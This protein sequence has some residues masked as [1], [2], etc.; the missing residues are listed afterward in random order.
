MNTSNYYPGARGSRPTPLTGT[1]SAMVLLVAS[2]APSTVVWA[3][4]EWQSSVSLQSEYTDNAN[5]SATDPL[6]ERQD[7]VRLSTGGSY[8]NSLLEVSA[9]YQASETYFE[10]DSQ[11]NR[12]QLQGESSLL[13]GK[14]H[15]PLDLLVSHSR[16]M[17]LNAPDDLDLLRNNDERDIFTVSPSARWR[18]DGADTVILRATWADIGYRFT[19]QRD[20]ERTSGSLSWER[21]LSQT[22]Q[23]NLSAQQSDVSFDA[24]PFADYKYNAAYAAY[25]TQLRQLDYRIQLGYNESKP[26]LGEGLSSPAYQLNVGYDSGPHQWNFNASTRITDNSAGSGNEES[27]EGFNPGDA[28]SG[29]LDQLERTSG[30]LS[31]QTQVVCGRCSLSVSFYYQDDDYRVEAEDRQQSGIRINHDYRLSSQASLGFSLD[32][33]NHSFA[34]D[35]ARE[36]YRSNRVGVSYHYR[37]VQGLELSVFSNW[38]DRESDGPAPSY[39]ELRGGLGLTYSF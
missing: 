29:S 37:F 20:S 36:D 21:E 8:E 22:S 2:L 31:W 28:S 25:S 23:F 16:R 24:A 35:V 27:F 9:N 15:Q 14:P 13:L 1:C 18:S 34:P 10:K 5:R 26:E 38:R 30:E 17:V 3:D 11:E 32:R 6:S 39:D 4:G 12:S 19:P 7:E 33:R